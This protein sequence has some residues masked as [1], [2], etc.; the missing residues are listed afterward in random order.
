MSGKEVWNYEQLESEPLHWYEVFKRYYMLTGLSRSVRKAYVQ[1]LENEKPGSDQL[2]RATRDKIGSRTGHYWYDIAL[3]YFWKER[4]NAW[5][6]ERTEEFK[7]EVQ[8]ARIL[9]MALT[10]DAVDALAGAL[11]LPR[12]QVQAA[13]E[14]LD[15]AGIPATARLDVDATLQLTADEMAK[16]KDEATEW[17][18]SM[19]EE[20]G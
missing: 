7:K 3:K 11:K 18:N 9:L 20:S 17:E 15:R 6:Q 5:D 19:L 2:S 12:S 8:E 1:F 4:A 16:A 10:P 13:K 14:I